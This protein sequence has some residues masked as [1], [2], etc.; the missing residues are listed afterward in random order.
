MGED[1]LGCSFS[2]HGNRGGYVI[3]VNVLNNGHPNFYVEKL[4]PASL[5]NYFLDSY[6]SWLPDL[7]KTCQ[8]SILPIHKKALART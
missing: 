7:K 6:F 8:I 1:K 4:I 3:L 2:K 5:I